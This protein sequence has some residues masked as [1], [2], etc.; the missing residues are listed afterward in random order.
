MGRRIGALVRNKTDLTAYAGIGDGISSAIREIVLTGTLDKL[1]K[2]RSGISPELME[3]SAFPRLDPK[4]VLRI[5]KK[6]GISST[7]ALRASLENGA[8]AR[9]LGAR[10][11]QHVSQGLGEAHAIL[12]SRAHDLRLAVEEFLLGKASARRVAAAGDYRRRVE[13][14]ELAGLGEVGSAGGPRA[15]TAYSTSATRSR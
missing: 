1:E 13:V 7:D 6:L 4:Q 14:I 11:A 12:L 10:A 3:I 15:G 5:Y 2:I 9:V 8:I